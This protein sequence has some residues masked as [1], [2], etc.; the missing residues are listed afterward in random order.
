M[1][2]SDGYPISGKLRRPI[3]GLLPDT[4]YL[5]REHE[6]SLPLSPPCHQQPLSSSFASVKVGKLKN[7]LNLV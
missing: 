7:R 2:P 1:Q 4:L 5:T 6:S 3:Q